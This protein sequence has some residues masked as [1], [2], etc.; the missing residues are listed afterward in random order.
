[1]ISG[2]EKAPRREL[3]HS[4]RTR[5]NITENRTHLGENLIGQMAYNIVLVRHDV[6]IAYILTQDGSATRRTR[7][8]IEYNMVW[9]VLS[10]VGQR[11]HPDEIC[12]SVQRIVAYD[13]KGACST[14]LHRPISGVEFGDNDI[15][16]FRSTHLSHPR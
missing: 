16:S 13:E 11:T 15:A 14:K 12:Y 3:F 4:S 7:L 5:K 1:M 2:K 6:E 10:F 9:A 8:L